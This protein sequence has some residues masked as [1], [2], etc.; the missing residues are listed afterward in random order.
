MNY[1]DD[2]IAN[3]EDRI[4][5]YRLRLVKQFSAMEQ[6]MSQMQS[7]KYQYDKFPLIYI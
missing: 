5:R 6:A 4:E 3:L 2:K 1:A 7:T